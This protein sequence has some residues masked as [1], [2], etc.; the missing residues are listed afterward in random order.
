MEPV[1]RSGRNENQDLALP[2]GL[3]PGPPLARAS[4]FIPRQLCSE[5][6]HSPLGVRASSGVQP[7]GPV[8]WGW[9]GGGGGWGVLRTD[10]WRR[11]SL[12][13]GLESPSFS[14]PVSSPVKWDG[15]AHLSVGVR[16]L[17]TLW[18]EEQYW[19]EVGIL[20]VRSSLGNHLLQTLDFEM[21]KP[22]SREAPSAAESTTSG[23]Q[24]LSLS[25]ASR[26]GV[27]KDHVSD[28]F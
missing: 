22:R 1:G 18:V 13:C 9:G 7:S 26:L 10:V 17:K 21:G 20:R 19:Y 3:P 28:K 4:A 11:C 8:S 14:E 25:T 24:R 5:P 27:F 15:R 6:D 2:P 16:P 12:H 23:L